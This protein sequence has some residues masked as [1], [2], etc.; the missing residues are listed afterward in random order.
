VNSNTNDIA[1]VLKKVNI[2]AEMEK[3]IAY[4]KIDCEREL[5]IEKGKEYIYP[6]KYNEWE[7][8]IRTFTDKSI[9]TPETIVTF[10]SAIDV[11]LK[12]IEELEHEKAYNVSIRVNNALYPIT[13][14]EFIRNIVLRFANNG[15]SFFELTDYKGITL[16]ERQAILRHKNRNEELKRL[17]SSSLSGHKSIIKKW[18]H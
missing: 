18:K 10:V 5:W 8:F 7:N 14:L 11:T 6:E 2:T 13:V 4:E 17:N 15:P 3:R 9:C 1:K 12:I 16:D